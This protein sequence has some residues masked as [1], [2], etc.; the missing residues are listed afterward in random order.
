MTNNQGS[1][2]PQ[3]AAL[4]A[5]IRLESV[6]HRQASKEKK[7]RTEDADDAGLSVA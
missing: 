1:V 3:A 7:E 4:D 2:S 5:F 6:S